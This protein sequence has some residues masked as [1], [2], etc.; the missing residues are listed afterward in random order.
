MESKSA[1]TNRE[2]IVPR[3]L[4]G[5]H[6]YLRPLEAGDLRHIQKWVNYYGHRYH[7]FVMMSILEDEYRAL[8]RG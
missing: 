3:F 8:R 2:N 1:V 7:D 4:I 5:E 6:V